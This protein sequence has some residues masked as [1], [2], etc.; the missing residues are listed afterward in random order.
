VHRP[1]QHPLFRNIKMVDAAAELAEAGVEV[2]RAIVRPSFAGPRFL[3]LTM[4][5]PDSVM[6]ITLEEAGK[7]GRHEWVA[8]WARVD[9]HL[10][11]LAGCGG[12]ARGKRWAN[13]GAQPARKRRHGRWAWCAALGPACMPMLSQRL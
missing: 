10:D 1:I 3:C 6:H 8:G 7:V 9:H 13:L 12:R 11:R 5:T 4:R 2:G